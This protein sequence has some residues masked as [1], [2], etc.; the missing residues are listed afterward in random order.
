[1]SERRRAGAERRECT[2]KNKNPTQRCGEKGM[3]N[4]YL[5]Q[6]G[7]SKRNRRFPVLLVWNTPEQVQEP[8]QSEPV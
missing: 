1:M 6:N 5:S 7:T 2:T 4:K 3:K 8:N